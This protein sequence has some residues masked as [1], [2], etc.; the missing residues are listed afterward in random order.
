M[1]PDLAI[2]VVINSLAYF[3]LSFG[4][5]FICNCKILFIIPF[6]IF[7]LIYIFIYQPLLSSYHVNCGFSARSLRTNAV[8]HAFIDVCV[9]FVDRTHNLFW[10]SDP[11]RLMVTTK[12]NE[13]SNTVSLARVAEMFMPKNIYWDI[14]GRLERNTKENNWPW[15]LGD[16][17]FHNSL[18]FIKNFRMLKTKDD[19]M[20]RAYNTYRWYEQCVH[21]FCREIS[22]EEII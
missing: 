3:C 22:M 21:N 16:K 6:K 18:I 15:W 20:S 4:H 1:Q 5:C 13:Q 8:A 19:G 7:T 2:F 17:E 9:N 10:P 11:K 14:W 12:L